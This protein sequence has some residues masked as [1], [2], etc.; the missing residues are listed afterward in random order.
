MLMTGDLSSA[1]SFTP[2]PSF[3]S[4]GTVFDM[5][6]DLKPRINAAQHLYN[7]IARIGTL[8]RRRSPA[9]T[10]NEASDDHSDPMNG[11]EASSGGALPVSPP[12]NLSGRLLKVVVSDS[13]AK[14]DLCKLVRTVTIPV[15]LMPFSPQIV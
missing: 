2:L 14:A 10:A 12:N 7:E 5:S 3:G 15:E 1:Q 9:G 13:A 4:S 6:S 8:E 11:T